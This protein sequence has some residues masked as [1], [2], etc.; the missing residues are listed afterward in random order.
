MLIK[1]ISNFLSGK[2]SICLLSS[3]LLLSTSVCFGAENLWQVLDQE[4]HSLDIMGLQS[5]SGEFAIV[6]AQYVEIPLTSPAE[7]EMSQIVP[8]LVRKQLYILRVANNNTIVWRKGYPALPDV[9]EIFSISTA[10]DQR[11]CILFGE[12]L[13]KEAVLNP[14]LSQVDAAGKILWAKRDVIS[15]LD[16][17]INNSESVE[18]IANLDTLRVVTSPTNGCVVTFVTRQFLNEIESIKLHVIQYSPDGAI[19]WR[20]ALDT[21]MYG[22]LFFIH[23]NEAN[24]YVIIQTNQSRDAAIEA[25]ML[26]MPFVPETALVGVG[27]KGEI[28]YQISRP[29]SLSNVWVRDA[30]DTTG[31]ELLL[32][33]KIKS[34]WAG[35][36]NRSGNVL[37]YIDALEGEFNA[38]SETESGGYLFARGDNLTLLDDELKTF[39]DQKIKDVTI[40]QYVNKYL[41][42]RLPDD[43]P[44]EQMILLDENEY[45][46]LYKLGSKLLK[47]RLNTNGK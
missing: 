37:S 10:R 41:M 14:V 13:G 32:A 40:A 4:G 2:C 12:Q 35:Q 45:L 20:K 43:L 38:V 7:T 26:A 31:D 29:E 44:V 1:S 6:G 33:G 42:A 17:N 18:Q 21:D 27:Y 23:N 46:V 22:K 15:S 5:Y 3:Y 9:H 30:Y 16:A 36:I 28:L 8:P 47:V 39:S 24:N 19:Q 11:L 34:A 25:M